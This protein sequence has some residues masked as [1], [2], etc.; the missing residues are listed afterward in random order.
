MLLLI[1][2]LNNY[3][4]CRVSRTEQGM[5]K[6]HRKLARKIAYLQDLLINH[7]WYPVLFLLIL[8][9]LAI[10]P[11]LGVTGLRDWDEGI[12]AA[13]SRNLLQTGD[14]FNLRLGDSPYFNKPPLFFILT[15]FSFKVFGYNEFA[16]RFFSAGFAIGYLLIGYLLARR[17]FSN[18]IAFLSVLFTLAHAHFLQISRHGRMESM[19]AFFILLSVYALVRS[20]ENRK[21]LYLFFLASALG[22]LTKGAMALIPFGVFLIV[23]IVKKEVRRL[24]LSIHFWTGGLLFIIVSLSWFTVE[25]NL[26]GHAY[27]DEFLGR[28]TIGRITTVIEQHNGNIFYSLN[29]ICFRYFSTWGFIFIPALIGLII[30]S[31]KKQSFERILILVLILSGLLFFGIM[32]STKLPWYTYYLYLPAALVCAVF[33]SDLPRWFSWLRIVLVVISL[34]YIGASNFTFPRD[35]QGYKPFQ[36]VFSSYLVPGSRLYSYQLD[37]PALQF[38]A[39]CSI[40]NF[41][42]PEIFKTQVGQTEG[43]YISKTSDFQHL[44]DNYPVKIIYENSDFVFF[45]NDTLLNKK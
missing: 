38:Y 37:Q 17:L 22:V 19:V 21:W 7:R 15:A 44:T 43:F 27:L 13:V 11:T 29:I 36:P 41:T 10:F 3:F 45:K 24:F 20:I 39:N 1:F 23:S 28:Q 40:I 14:W 4:L 2:N 26:Y 30:A 5:N 31:I 8:S 9:G 34:G 32:V 16:A 18:K 12:Y 6:I 25:Y 42:E 35:Y 33:L